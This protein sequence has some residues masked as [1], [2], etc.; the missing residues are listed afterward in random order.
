VKLAAPALAPS[1]VAPVAFAARQERR[2]QHDGPSVAA[3][4]QLFALLAGV[5]AG[6]EGF[7]TAS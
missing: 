3:D 2:S 4:E 7:A 6:V 5:S 1:R